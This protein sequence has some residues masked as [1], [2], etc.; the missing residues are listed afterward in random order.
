MRSPRG[1]AGAEREPVPSQPYQAHKPQTR[2]V[3]T[4]GRASAGAAAAALTSL[5]CFAGSAEAQSAP[6][7]VGNGFALQQF[8]PAPSGDR[9]FGIPDAAVMGHGKGYFTLLGDYALKPLKLH[10]QTQN[11]NLGYLTST[12]LYA[13]LD[14]TI[15][16]WNRL[17]INVDIPI[18]LAQSGDSNSTLASSLPAG[19][20]PGNPTGGKLG[21]IRVT[22]RIGLVGTYKD[23]FS[24]A[25]QGSLWLPTGSKDNLTSD[26]N[27]RGDG[28][29]VASGV[30]PGEKGGVGFYYAANVGA[31]GRK[32]QLLGAPSAVGTALEG[33]A[34]LGLLLADNKLS[35]G[36]EIYGNTV[37]T[38]STKFL[39]THTSPTEGVL[40]A[41]LRLGDFQIGLAG[42]PGFTKAPGTPQ[43]RGLLSIG[44]VPLPDETPPD[45]DG[46]G[47]TDDKDACPT[48][49]G[50]PSADPTKNGCPPPPPP[51]DRD[52]DGIPDAQDACPDT[53][54]VANAD[55]SKNGCPA[56]RDGDGIPDAQDACPD[57][58]GVANADP[59][60]N[61]CPAD[62][63][64]DG[65]P[66]SVDACPDTPG[67]KSDDP[68]KNGCPS[69]R[70]GDGIPDAQD[71]CPDTAGQADPDPKKNGCPHLAQIVGTEIRIAEQVHF[72]TGKAIIKSDSDKL[73]GEVAGI[74]KEHAEIGK[75]SI[76]G[77][78]DNKGA[79]GANKQLSQKRAE[80]VRDW[81]VKKGNIARTRLDAKGWGQ[82]KPIADNA[83]EE[84]R[85]LNRRVEFHI[86][87]SNKALTTTTTTTKT[88]APKPPKKK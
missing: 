19:A 50:V 51:P 74:L 17:L 75:V 87:D 66:D 58:A 22:A 21:D 55:P 59:K 42:G 6:S 41:K 24:L 16:L 28:R 33:G 4:R 62:R 8:E 60:K 7:V 83:T 65:I 70:D 26:G 82:E 67:V 78:T 1:C 71:A 36:P 47:I 13:N 44:Y 72:E 45:T 2:A 34:G 12:Q 80:A 63:D 15:A 69:D 57:V 43:F 46:D 11:T 88:Q 20:V 40:G 54:G 77:H 53:P 61:G 56:D 37:V 73:L 84:G 32:Y 85:A 10:D 39:G 30:I 5:L 49:K 79:K 3:V 38:N 52:G 25:I 31:Y 48:V 76:E 27:V 64:G 14:G 18:A 68:K 35:I 9:F 86:L 23:P 29:L 81:L